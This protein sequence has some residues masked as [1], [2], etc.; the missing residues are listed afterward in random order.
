MQ[1]LLGL[2]YAGYVGKGHAGFVAHEHARPAAPKA[3]GLVAAP[4]GLPHHKQDDGPE[5]DEGQEVYEYGEDV[6]KSAGPLH[7]YLNAR[8]IGSCVPQHLIDAGA[9]LLARP[10]DVVS[11]VH[12]PERVLAYLNAPHLPALHHLDN[13]AD[14]Y[15]PR[16]GGRLEKGEEYGNHRHYYEEVDKAI[17]YP[18]TVHQMPICATLGI[19]IS[20]LP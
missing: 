1:F 9:T 19:T 5:E 16:P 13:L 2:F 3:H 4:L 10:E 17:S 7:P 12:H 11:N 18:L 20:I 14:G 15:I 8:S 6:S